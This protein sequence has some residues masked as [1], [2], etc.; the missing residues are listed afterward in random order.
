MWFA[1]GLVYFAFYA[2]KRLVLSP[3][4]EFAQKWN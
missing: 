4:E 3:E 2:Q 1:L